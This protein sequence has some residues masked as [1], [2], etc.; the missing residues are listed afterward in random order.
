MASRWTQAQVTILI[1]NRTNGFWERTRIYFAGAGEEI[2]P[3]GESLDKNELGRQALL[4]EPRLEGHVGVG[5]SEMSIGVDTGAEKLP[6][7]R[8][9]LLEEL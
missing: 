6:A 5:G 7:H 4:V 1:E 8:I 2:R 3:D 9:V